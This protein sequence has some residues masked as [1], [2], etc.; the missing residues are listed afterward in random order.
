M[1]DQTIYVAGSRSISVVQI[2]HAPAHDRNGSGGD[3]S[4][5]VQWR[6]DMSLLVGL[7]L[8]TIT[9]QTAWQMVP[10]LTSLIRPSGTSGPAIY[11]DTNANDPALETDPNDSTRFG[12][13]HY[14]D[15]VGS[16]TYITV[17]AGDW[18]YP[19]FASGDSP[20]RAAD[21][22]DKSQVIIGTS[23]LYL[24]DT[25]DAIDPSTGTVD[26]SL[27]ANPMNWSRVFDPQD[28]DDDPSSDPT[29]IFSKLERNYRQTAASCDRLYVDCKY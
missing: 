28:F 18:V 7:S 24:N 1:G 23:K 20:H 19:I 17:T 16:L 3:V 25:G 11:Q 13:R 15:L 14:F 4:L 22:N 21:P 6:V 8:I 10:R 5:S 9:Q 2:L 26:Y 12:D 29:T 27:V